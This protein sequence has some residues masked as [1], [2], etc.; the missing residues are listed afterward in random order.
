VLPGGIWAIPAYFNGTVYY[1]SV[2][3]P[4]QA[5]TF[6]N[7]KLSSNSTAQTGD[8][9]SYP[10]ALPSVSA[11]GTSNGIVWAVESVQVAVLHAYDATDL[12]EIYNTNQASDG[13]DHFGGGNKFITATIVNGKVFVANRNGVAM[14]GLLPQ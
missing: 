13:R 1:G 2:G 9:F 3:G 5:F 4:I 10:G 6:T 12:N 11:N 8:T 7:A 14:F